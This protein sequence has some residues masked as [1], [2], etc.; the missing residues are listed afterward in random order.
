MTI[1]KAKA[2]DYLSVNVEGVTRYIQE[3]AQTINDY[4]NGICGEGEEL[5][6]KNKT[7][8]NTIAAELETVKKRLDYILYGKY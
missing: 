4:V 6:E 1:H 5:A 7:Q 3:Y 8:L 2:S